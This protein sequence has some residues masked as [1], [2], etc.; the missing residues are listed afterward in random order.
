MMVGDAHFDLLITPELTTF[1]Q[2]RGEQWYRLKRA[3]APF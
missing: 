3:P 2:L 1:G